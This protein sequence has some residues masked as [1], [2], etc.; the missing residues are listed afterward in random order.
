M[1][2]SLFNRV[3]SWLDYL[4]QEAVYSCEFSVLTQFQLLQFSTLFKLLLLTLTLYMILSWCPLLGVNTEERKKKNI[5]DSHLK[6]YVSLGED[7]AGL[8]TTVV[9]GCQFSGHCGLWHSSRYSPR[10]SIVPVPY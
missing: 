7:R 3:T 6:W 2:F 5:K 9:L 1:L 10:S 8:S 4:P